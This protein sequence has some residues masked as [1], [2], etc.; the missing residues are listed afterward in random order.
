MSELIL[1]AIVAEL[2]EWERTGLPPLPDQRGKI[3]ETLGRFLVEGPADCSAAVRFLNEHFQ[4]DMR[5]GR[6]HAG[7]EPGDALVALLGELLELRRGAQDAALARVERNAAVAEVADY[8]EV[9]EL[10]QRELAHLRRRN[11]ELMDADSASHA[12]VVA[13]VKERDAWRKLAQC[14]ETARRIDPRM[15]EGDLL[16]AEVEISD[17]KDELRALG[18]NQGSW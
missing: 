11:V 17:A 16:D 1:R 5:T 13:L 15:N 7:Q 8:A 2:V 10:D 14:S 6:L 9:R 4:E 12:E 3:L 18:I